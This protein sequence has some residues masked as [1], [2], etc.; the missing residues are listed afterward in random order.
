MAYNVLFVCTTNSASSIIAEALL[1]SLSGGRFRAY[2]GGD[3][4][5]GRVDP[6]ALEVLRDSG[7]ATTNLRSKAWEEF[8]GPRAPT[9]D[10]VISVRDAHV[11]PFDPVLPGRPIPSR[12]DMA[13]PEE[14]Q[15][16][17]GRRMAMVQAL[18]VLRRRVQ[19]LTS[20]PFDAFDKTVL[21]PV[22]DE[23]GRF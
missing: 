3:H 16:E 9:M 7:Y 12:W 6:L 11:V 22:L 5:A 18:R 10:F 8:T 1:N 21:G 2:S 14:A 19:H 20:V 13:D 4:A 15:T 23:I 17:E